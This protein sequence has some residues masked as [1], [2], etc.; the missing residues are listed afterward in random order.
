MKQRFRWDHREDFLL[1]YYESTWHFVPV[2][3]A[4]DASLL[5]LET[6]MCCVCLLRILFG[7]FSSHVLRLRVDVKIDSSHF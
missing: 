7:A 3:S 1:T 5:T 4:K 2:L 6:F